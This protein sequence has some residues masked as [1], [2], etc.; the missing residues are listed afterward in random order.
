MSIEQIKDKIIENAKEDA[1]RIFDKGRMESRAKVYEAQRIAK[2]KVEEA[3]EKGHKRCGYYKISQ[4][5]YGQ[6]GGSQ[7]AVGCKAICY[8]ELLF[9][10][11]FGTKKTSAQTIYKYAFRKAARNGPRKRRNPLKQ[12][13]P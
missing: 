2:I 9:R 5:I 11:A 6:L 7:N 8:F 12:K 4:K 3:R 1:R 10:R 13:G